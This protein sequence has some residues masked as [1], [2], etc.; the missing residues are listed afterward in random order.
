MRSQL[1][2]RGELWVAD[3]STTRGHE[4]S[5]RRPCLVLSTDIFNH[6][7]AGLTVII[8][9]TTRDKRIPIHVPI[10][11]NESGLDE[12]S[13]IKCEDLRSVSVERLENRVG[14]VPAST[15]E[16]VADRVRILLEL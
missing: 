12:R 13:F 6:G 5:G 11:A 4:Q 10:E 1:P 14:K 16:I 9:L 3:L 15:M 8:P 7:P 2:S